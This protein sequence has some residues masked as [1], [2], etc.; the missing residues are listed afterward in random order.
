MRSPD[1][2]KP[3]RWQGNCFCN[4]R[5]LDSASMIVISSRTPVAREA[6]A[7]RLVPSVLLALLSGFLLNLP[8]PIAGPL[9][10]WR[11][12]FGWIA[13]IP[14][15]Y[16]LLAP[17]SAAHPRYLRRSTLAAYFGGVFWYTLNSYWIYQTMHL[18]AGVAPA[19]AVGILI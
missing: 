7:A 10:P 8:F 19:G 11:A 14:L 1:D 5:M 9:P 2:C 18:Y 15:L 6:A 16:A 13:L 4:L 12:A 17:G 3:A